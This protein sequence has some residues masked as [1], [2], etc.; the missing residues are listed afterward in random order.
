[1]INFSD[2]DESVALFVVSI[3]DPWR[4][5]DQAHATES[6]QQ[7]PAGPVDTIENYLQLRNSTHKVVIINGFKFKGKSTGQAMSFKRPFGPVSLE[8]EKDCPYLQYLR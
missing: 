3:V 7:I 5:G 1:M 8:I 2:R 4:K 6:Q